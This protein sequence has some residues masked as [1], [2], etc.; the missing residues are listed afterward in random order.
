[1]AKIALAD[2][3]AELRAELMRARAQGDAMQ[4]GEDSE[5]DSEP[6]RF[7]VVDAEI[8]LQVTASTEDGGSGGIKFWVVTAGVESK[9]GK[10]SIQT[11][12]LKLSPVDS[13]GKPYLI[14]RGD[15]R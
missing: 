7:G 9:A 8:E 6:V 12:R 4:A 10:S 11:L 3:I 5:E 14:S 15:T 13:E 2:M 1:M